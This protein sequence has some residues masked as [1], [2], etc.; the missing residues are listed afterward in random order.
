M[1]IIKTISSFKLFHNGWQQ[2]CFY[3]IYPV[4][5]TKMCSLGVEKVHSWKRILFNFYVMWKTFF[6]RSS[7]CSYCAVRKY[8]V[9]AVTERKCIIIVRYMFRCF[10]LTQP[11]CHQSSPKWCLMYHCW[12]SFFC[13]EIFLVENEWCNL[14]NVLWWLSEICHTLK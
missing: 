14:T 12:L 3:L 8:P 5:S 13:K 2:H 7:G 4:L 6:S 1:M 10:L 9:F 11:G